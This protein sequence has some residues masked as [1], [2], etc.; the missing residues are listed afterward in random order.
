MT[1]SEQLFGFD[2]DALGLI[3]GSYQG[4]SEIHVCCPF[5]GGNGKSAEFNIIDGKF[6]CFKCGARADAYAIAR[7]FGGQVVRR[8]F[9]KKQSDDESWRANLQAPV[10]ERNSYL[11][12]RGVTPEQIKRYEIRSLDDGVGIP[13]KDHRGTVKGI[14]VRKYKGSFRYLNGGE[15]LSG[16]PLQNMVKFDRRDPLVIVEGIFGALRG[17]KYGYNTVATLGAMVK[18]ELVIKWA[19]QFRQVIVVFDPDIGGYNGYQKILKWLPSA[20]VALPGFAVDESDGT[21]WDYIVNK[22]KKTNDPFVLKRILRNFK[23]GKGD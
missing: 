13:I 2:P 17:E 7:Q 3:R 21:M 8:F 9:D 1:F 10:D 11:L 14:V 6:Y 15:R 16:W 23:D 19:S 22:A 4:K 20:Q 5:H 18:K 12:G